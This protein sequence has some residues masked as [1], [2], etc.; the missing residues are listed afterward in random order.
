MI[1]R[2]NTCWQPD[3]WTLSRR[4]PL[5]EKMKS[6]LVLAQT[7][8][9]KLKQIDA[10]GQDTLIVTSDGIHDHVSIDDMEDICCAEDNKREFCKKL[11]EQAVENGSMDDI[12][13]VVLNKE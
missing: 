6:Q 9:L 8:R 1:P 2:W 5:N 11:I 10:S 13:V 3:N 12:S 4:N 7:I